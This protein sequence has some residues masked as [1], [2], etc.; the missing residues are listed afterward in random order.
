MEPKFTPIK[1]IKSQQEYTAQ[2]QNKFMEI[3]SPLGWNINFVAGD[4]IIGGPLLNETNPMQTNNGRIKKLNEMFVR[5]PFPKPT[6]AGGNHK[7]RLTM[8]NRKR[9]RKHRRTHKK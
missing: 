2:L 7:K 3:I 5:I 1:N 4:N 9:N 6:K 8:H